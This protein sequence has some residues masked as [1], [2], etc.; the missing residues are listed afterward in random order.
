[1]V[2]IEDS[3]MELYRSQNL[4]SPWAGPGAYILLERGSEA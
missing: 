3:G 4:V 2:T 1:M